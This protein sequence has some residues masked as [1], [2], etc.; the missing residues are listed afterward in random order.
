MEL[1]LVWIYWVICLSLVTYISAFVINRYREY[2]YALL[3]GFY[4]V[5]L[6]ASQILATRLI[7]FDLGFYV[8][9]A[10]AAVFLYPFLSQAIDMINEVYGEKKTHTAIIIAFLTQVMLVLFIL[11][12]ATLQPAPFFEHEQAW[13]ELFTQGIRITIASWASFLIFQNLDAYIFAWLKKNYPKRVFLRSAA[14]DIT[15][16]SFDSVVFITIAFYGIAPVM[17]LILG[18]IVAKNL[19]G[20]LDTPWFL[21]YKRYLEDKL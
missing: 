13:K 11:M 17:P 21:W 15:G 5:Y 7:E 9:F 18:Q 8:F 16:L 10:P 12:T 14:S 4:V 2:G 6:A 20:L 3:V 1:P 19:I